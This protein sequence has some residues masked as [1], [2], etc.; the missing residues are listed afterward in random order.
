MPKGQSK[1]PAATSRKI[2]EAN[3]KAW[4]DPEYRKMM[5]EK[6]SER[7]K[8]K[9]MSDEARRNMSKAQKGKKRGPYSEE[10]C[11]AISESL[12]GRKLSEEHKRKVSEGHKGK[13]TWNKGMKGVWIGHNSKD[14][15]TEAEKRFAELHPD[16]EQEV[17]FGTKI[18]G[19]P[20]VWKATWFR[21][22]FIDRKNKIVYEI[23]GPQH[24]KPE[25]IERDNRKDAFFRSIGWKVIRYKNDEIL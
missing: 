3:K 20:K 7:S 10:H 12:K 2:S 4:Q 21:A 18:S 13:P 6:L 15:P 24:Q 25:K 11:K 9:K 19:G 5:S 14:G 1:N 17:T 8:G 23:D 22:D 16:F